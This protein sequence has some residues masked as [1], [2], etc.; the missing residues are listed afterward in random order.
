MKQN[1]ARDIHEIL[2]NTNLIEIGPC[3]D[4][5]MLLRNKGNWVDLGLPWKFELYPVD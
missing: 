4:Y 2:L 3:V 5:I 1:T